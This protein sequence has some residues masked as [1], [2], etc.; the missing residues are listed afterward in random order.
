VFA[1]T[2]TLAEAARAIRETEKL[3][4]EP[5]APTLPATPD[6]APEGRMG[7]C[8]YEEVT[9]VTDKSICINQFKGL[10]RDLTRRFNLEEIH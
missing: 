5:K 3:G 2:K 4:R 10:V 9:P 6:P 1:G 7:P 8:G